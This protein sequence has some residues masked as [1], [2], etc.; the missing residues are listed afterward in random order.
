MS[1][2]IDRRRRL[3]CREDGANIA[4]TQREWRVLMALVDADG[5]ILD[6]VELCRQA[7]GWEHEF[8]KQEAQDIVKMYIYRVRKAIEE[9]PSEPRHVLNRF[10][11]G[12]YVE[13]IA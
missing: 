10:G 12:Y 11:F 9:Q 6:C 8:S 5:E 4:L 3:V 13:G 2:S 7:L 1:I